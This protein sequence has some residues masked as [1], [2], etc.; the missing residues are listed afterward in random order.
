MTQ[1]NRLAPD[2]AHGFGGTL[3]RRDRPLRFR[4]D[5]EWIEGFEGDTVLSAALANGIV[6]AGRHD[7]HPLALTTDFAP[8]VRQRTDDDTT[9]LPAARTPAIDG[10]DLVS[11]A[12]DR[13]ATD[14]PG[15][16]SALRR[17]FSRER[18]LMRHRYGDTATA[19]PPWI[20]A[21][22]SETLSADLVVVG[23][24]IAGL[25]AAGAAA[26]LSKRV[27]VLE[28]RPTHGGLLHYFGSIEGED[29]PDTLLEGLVT[30]LD[31]RGSVRIESATEAF[32]I[33]QG[34]VIAH[35]IGVAGGRASGQVLEIETGAVVIATG[36]GERLPIFPGNRL[37][38]V[39][40]ATSSFLMA[41][42]HGVWLGR[43]T[44]VA[45]PNSHAYRLAIYAADA[46]QPVQRIVD[47]RLAPHSRFIDFCKASG[48]TLASGL[49]VS[50]AS[51]TKDA[52]LQVAFAASNEGGQRA[53][54]NLG[55]DMLVAAGSFQPELGL[56]VSAGGEVGWNAAT[57]AIAPVGSIDGVRIVGSAAGWRSNTG[58]IASGRAA[59]LELMGTTAPS[60]DER[61]VPVQFETP[62]APVPISTNRSEANGVAYFDRG[63]SL[64]AGA[65]PAHPGPLSLGDVAAA[66]A[67]GLL[68]SAEVNT[69]VRERTGLMTEL[70]P[71]SW[72]PTAPPNNDIV[73]PYLAGR[74]GPKPLI[75]KL[76]APDAKPFSPGSLIFRTHDVG[77]PLN[78][79]GVVIAAPPPGE[80]GGTALIADPPET[81]DVLIFVNE[82][83]GASPARVVERGGTART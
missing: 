67:T 9:S 81:P 29:G 1:V 40:G 41:L 60:I 49:M 75:C 56:W 47:A 78:A 11:L 72:V 28:R 36:S 42:D 7:G 53:G 71:S 65:G 32:R 5:G 57:Q 2:A 73:P 52:G 21:A 70:P 79:I 66:V 69:F 22:P 38:G 46:G 24:G 54:A 34:K 33:G 19:S 44:T 68:P 80:S 74:F 8:L 35:R 58:A 55:T 82:T 64:F 10:A 31:G 83:G 37:P 27:I 76:A 6:S 15:W 26:A 4:L 30:G 39:V 61:L 25:A 18:G 14:A 12:P 59:T 50:E 3:L 23:A 16:L 77:D 13:S 63:A 20:S 51:Q 48:I 43:R 17:S 45:T 62:D